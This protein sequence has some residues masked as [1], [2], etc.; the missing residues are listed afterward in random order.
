MN[1]KGIAIVV[2]VALVAFAVTG[3]L[4]GWFDTPM[5]LGNDA[6][7]NQKDEIDRLAIKARRS[8][9]FGAALVRAEVRRG[10]PIRTA[11]MADAYVDAI[12]GLDRKQRDTVRTA[13]LR[14]LELR[15]P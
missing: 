15:S 2:F 3:D 7:Q 4:R 8:C 13:C 1:L 10:R 5:H 12:R 14:G 9:R 6:E 11:R